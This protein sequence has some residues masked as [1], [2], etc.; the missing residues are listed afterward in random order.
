MCIRDRYGHPCDIERTAQIAEIYGLR[1]LYDAAHAFGVKV[2][3]GSLLNHG[4]LSIL[5]FHATKKFNTMEGGAIITNDEKLKKRIDYLKNFGFADEVTVVGPGINAKMNEFQAALGLLQLDR[6][7]TVV[8]KNKEITFLYREHLRHVPGLTF[9]LDTDNV[10]YNYS[11]F[12]V[13]I[14]EHRF[15]LS[16]DALYDKLKQNNIFARRYF[17]PLISQFPTYRGLPSASPPNLPIA[18][19]ISK[20]ILCLPIYEDL[21]VEDVIRI[22]EIIKA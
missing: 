14:D 4:D 18:E 13:L 10:D 3:G 15:P 19:K 21:D 20:Q 6:F 1:V 17:Y 7:D 5:S 8:K 12:P 22:C 16:R 11:Y 2:K 9:F